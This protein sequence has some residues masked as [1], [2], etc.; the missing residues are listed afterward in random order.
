MIQKTL[1]ISL[2]TEAIRDTLLATGQV[3]LL[4]KKIKTRYSNLPLPKGW[5]AIKVIDGDYTETTLINI[6]GNPNFG[7]KELEPR[8][9]CNGMVF[10]IK[11]Y[12][13]LEIVDYDIEGLFSVSFDI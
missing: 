13:C 9:K 2:E 8:G 12:K 1:L 4:G 6:L 7:I 10:D 3:R 5:I 11:I